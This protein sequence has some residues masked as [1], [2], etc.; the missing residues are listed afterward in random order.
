MGWLAGVVLC[1]PVRD[2]E[3]LAAA[4]QSGG[5]VPEAMEDAAFSPPGEAD[6]GWERWERVGRMRLPEKTRSVDLP[7]R[8]AIR[9]FQKVVSPVDGPSC[10]FTPS[11]S[12]YG[13]QAVRKHGLLLGIGMT[14]ERI[15]R[16]HQ[17]DNPLR[18]PVVERQGEFY[19]LDPVESNDFW[20]A[21]GP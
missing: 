15:V 18:Y 21:D 10:E 17:P 1:V 7:V 4:A 13:I 20:W 6:T 16:N 9:F 5:S 2:G 8:W 14:T 19:Y 12:S 3:A 11:C